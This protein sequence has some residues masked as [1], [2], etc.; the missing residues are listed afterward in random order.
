MVGI[1]PG[2][3]EEIIVK[4]SN[5]KPSFSPEQARQLPA[6]AVDAK[7]DSFNRLSEGHF[8]QVFSYET[9]SGEERVLRLGQ[10]EYSFYADKYAHDQ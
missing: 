6:I 2:S 7:P 5:I 3:I 4:S 10:K 9:I 1:S 8:S